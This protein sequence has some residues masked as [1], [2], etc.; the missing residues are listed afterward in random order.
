MS[1]SKESVV[2]VVLGNL[3]AA[4]VARLTGQPLIF[5]ALAMVPLSWPLLHA[6]LHT[7]VSPGLNQVLART[8][9][10]EFLTCATVALLATV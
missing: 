2:L 8:G 4:P 6:I 5:L 9:Q 10:W 3:M 7:P 1:M